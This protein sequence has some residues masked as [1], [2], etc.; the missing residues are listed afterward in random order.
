VPDPPLLWAGFSLVCLF[1]CLFGIDFHPLP[2]PS[3]LAPPCCCSSSSSCSFSFTITT[4]AAAA[5]AAAFIPPVFIL[6]INLLLLLLL[7][8][9]PG[10]V[11]FS[12]V[13][14]CLQRRCEE[15]GGAD[16]TGSWFQRE[17]GDGS[18]LL[19][20]ACL[21][22]KR[23]AVIPLLLA[24]PDIDVNVKDDEDG[25]P[26]YWACHFGIT[27]CV[28]E[29][30]K[31]SRVEVNVPDRYDGLHSGMLLILATLVSSS[32]GLPLEGR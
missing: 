1:V 22:S 16:E 5:A 7:F 11:G 13:C 6:T 8:L 32:G 28:R 19:H 12:H 15:S 3:P 20:Y 25:G 30:L 24:H 26:F 21:D 10:I 23:S 17:H 18:T 31:D 29:M 4:A 9:L 2:T 14:C 27:P